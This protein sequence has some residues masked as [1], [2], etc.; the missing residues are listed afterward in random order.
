MQQV[1]IF[2]AVES[3]IAGLENDVNRWLAE[4]GARVLSIT[5]NISPQSKHQ[6]GGSDASGPFKYVPSDVL[7]IVLYEHVPSPA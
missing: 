6:G 7:L 3:E 4:S 2:K 5:G 1:K